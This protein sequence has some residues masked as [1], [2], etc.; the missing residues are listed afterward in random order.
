MASSLSGTPSS[1]RAAGGESS[2]WTPV[3][4]PT[5][6]A[7]QYASNGPAT[8]ESTPYT[9]RWAWRWSATS[10]GAPQPRISTTKAPATSR[11]TRGW[12]TCSR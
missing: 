4:T 8:K 11:R 10:S 1:R 3:P 9:P 6:R 7:V 2:T 5:V 12:A